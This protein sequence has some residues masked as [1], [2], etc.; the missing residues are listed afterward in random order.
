MNEH[1]HKPF[2][3]SKLK[4][5]ATKYLFPNMMDTESWDSQNTLKSSIGD[6]KTNIWDWK[7]IKYFYFKSWYFVM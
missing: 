1:I 7:G 6:N 2:W 5:Y 4:T 3:L